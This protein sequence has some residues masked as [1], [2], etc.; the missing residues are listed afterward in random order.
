MFLYY[1]FE[2][3]NL[4]IFLFYNFFLMRNNQIHT[5]NFSLQQFIICIMIVMIVGVMVLC[6]HNHILIVCTQKFNHINTKRLGNLM[7][8]FYVWIAFSTFNFSI[9]IFRH[10]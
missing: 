6:L 5:F 7:Q 8:T 9:T 3:M 1:A 4:L 2:Y 10:S